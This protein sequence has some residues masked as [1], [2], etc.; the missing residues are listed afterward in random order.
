MPCPPMTSWHEAGGVF[1]NVEG[2]PRAT[3]PP[4]GGNMFELTSLGLLKLTNREL[5]LDDHVEQRFMYLPLLCSSVGH[6]SDA[7]DRF[8]RREGYSN[9]SDL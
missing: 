1:A 4:C 2:L 5:S 7:V 6:T 8:S 3:E 9:M